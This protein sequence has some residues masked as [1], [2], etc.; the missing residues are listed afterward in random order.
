MKKENRKI[1]AKVAKKIG[2][3]LCDVGN[4]FVKNMFYAG[5]LAASMLTPFIPSDGQSYLQ[6]N[7]GISV[8]TQTRVSAVAE[9]LEGIGLYVYGVQS[10]YLEPYVPLIEKYSLHGLYATAL[11]IDMI[12]RVA[13]VRK[14]NIDTLFNADKNYP[15]AS[16]PVELAYGAIKSV[17]SAA[18]DYLKTIYEETKSEVKLESK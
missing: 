9:F 14:S 2:K 16:I 15:M 17:A 6:R 3:D 5:G 7:T 13:S 12:V 4:G 11:G 8:E 18:K 10:G 1:A